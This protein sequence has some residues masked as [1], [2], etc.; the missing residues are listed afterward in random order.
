MEKVSHSGKKKQARKAFEVH[1]DELSERMVLQIN[2]ADGMFPLILK[3]PFARAYEI[4][5]TKS[6]KLNMR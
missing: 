5:R 6:D 1:Y 4:V 2:D 3:V